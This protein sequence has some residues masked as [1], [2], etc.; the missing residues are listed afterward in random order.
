[1]SPVKKM[2]IKKEKNPG[3]TTGSETQ[4]MSTSELPQSENSNLESD[5][6][7]IPADSTAATPPTTPTASTSQLPPHPADRSRTTLFVSTIPYNATNE[8]LQEFFSEIGPVRTSYVVADREASEFRNKGYGYVTYALPEDAL[9]AIKELKKTKFMGVR[10]LK[11]EYAY[12]K[13]V[14]EERKAAGLPVEGETQPIKKMKADGNKTG[15]TPFSKPRDRPTTILISGLG[16]DI[17]KKQI[18]KKS[19]KFGDIKEVIFPVLKGDVPVPG[20]ALVVYSSGKDAENAIKHLDEHQF[21]GH[22]IQAKNVAEEQREAKRARLI[23]RNLPWQCTV[24]HL[25]KVFG[26]HGII[27][28]CSVPQGEN[29]KARGFG[30]VQ[31]AT[32][33]EAEK[34]TEAINGTEIMKRTVAV[35]WALP[36]AQYDRVV[37][38]EE[39]G[40]EED[41]EQDDQEEEIGDEEDIEE[42][43]QE[44]EEEDAEASVYIDTEGREEEPEEGQNQSEEDDGDDDGE[45]DEDAD[46]SRS[47][48]GEESASDDIEVSFDDRKSDVE[49]DIQEQPVPKRRDSAN[50]GLS[51][52]VTESCTLFIRNLSFDTSEEELSAALSTFGPLRY[53]RI[54]VDKSTGRS[55][56]TGFVCYKRQE[57]AAEC[58][59]AYDKASKA[60]ALLEAENHV[61]DADAKAA[62]RQKKLQPSKSILMPEPSLTAGATP[63]LVGGRF[64]NITL[65]VNRKQAAELAEEGKLRRR[66]EDKRNLYLMREGVIFPESDAAKSMTPSELSKRQESFAQ[67]KR[68]LTIN[69]NLY[70]SRTRLSVRNLGLKVD[71]KELKKVALLSVKKFWDEVKKGEREGMEPEVIKEE[72][73]EGRAAPSGTRKTVLKQAK[74]LRSKDRIDGTTKLPR[75]KG[76]GFI[77]FESHADALACLRWL[78][79][80]PRA[81][82]PPPSKKEDADMQAIEEPTSSRGKRPIVE[83]AIENRQVMKRREEREG[84]HKSAKRKRQGEEDGESGQPA[85]KRF[86]ETWK[87]RRLAQKAKKLLKQGDTPKEQGVAAGAA[88]ETHKNQNAAKNNKR[89]RD[90]GGSEK[91]GPAAKKNAKE[92]GKSKDGKLTPKVAAEIKPKPKSTAVPAPPSEDKKKKKKPKTTKVERRDQREEQNFDNLVQK[93]KK[94]LFGGASKE[95]SRGSTT[96]GEGGIKRW[97]A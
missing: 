6:P 42:D 1:M 51:A 32:P 23:V 34:A 61:G 60:A 78:N 58:L 45:E 33:G 66:A 93:Y 94:N 17:N 5:A 47:E 96:G 67:R 48:S 92:P 62:K 83:F 3:R 22:K 30:F 50:K 18:Y 85:K 65:A 24:E 7:R 54:T 70:I 38:E 59:A 56:G 36:K 15:S 16:V 79:N 53:A 88:V 89:K 41:I 73:D 29:G 76:Y 64:L 81:F 87:E 86:G 19:R 26:K 82:A 46:G 35:D 91:I 12:K 90:Q 57:D 43:D 55:R 97:F 49:N 75:S 9:R 21:K 69:P 31:F 80:N 72:E 10:T 37:A 74:I 8:Q 68:L 2:T 44:G 63:F 4:S 52:N 20:Q 11:I 25:R 40:D 95:A 84:Q 28:E 14:A 71:D 13:K 39:V 27:V 77:E